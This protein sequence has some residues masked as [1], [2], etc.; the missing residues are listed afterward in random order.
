MVVAKVPTDGPVWAATPRQALFLNAAEDEVLYGGA[1]GGGKSD[2]L[3]MFSILRRIAIPGSRGLILRRTFPE[4]ERSLILRSLELLA[5][6]GAAYQAQYKR[7]RFPNGSLLEFGYCERDE[8]VY[9]YQSAE[10][11]D[12]CFDE[13]TQFTEFQ[14]TYLMS[15]CRTTKSGV[16]TLIRAA[17]N[18][19][20]V[21]HGWVRSRFIDIAPWGERYTDPETGRTRRFIPAKL[22][23]NPYLAG[24]QYERMLAQLPEAERRA[25]RDG[26]WDV[27]AGQV[28]KEFSR[29]AHV[30]E[31]FPI[32]AGWRRWR[33]LDFGFTNPACVLWLALGPDETVY[34][35]RELYVTGM[36]AAEL[37]QRVVEMSR[38]ES[39]TLTLAD[40]AIFAKTGHEGESI[41]ETMRQNG[42]PCQKADNDRLAG[43]QRVHDYLTVFEGWDGNPTS[44]LKIFSTCTNLIRTLPQLVYDKTRPEDV[45]TDGEDHAYD[46]LRYA[47]MNRP[48]VATKRR[49]PNVPA[50]IS[51]ITGY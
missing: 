4:L 20:G 15:R 2:A 35:Y 33:A 32:P 28:F 7:W 10:Y 46:A 22:V 19:G 6:R 50:G 30:I 40:P 45:D 25:L 37:A 27:F 23:D 21:G 16:R 42:L 39:I 24:G 9:K 14:F 1:A 29:D 17:T 41:A 26:D 51:S 36:R 49:Q 18:P 44:R 12:I 11:E 34:V 43:K 13:L 31:P 5:G 3:L 8:D 38:G 48:A 47:L